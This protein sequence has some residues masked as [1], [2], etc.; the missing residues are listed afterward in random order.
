MLSVYWIAYQRNYK[1]PVAIRG[2]AAWYQLRSLMRRL[3][4]D[5]PTNM[6]VLYYA[7]S[8]AMDEWSTAV[9]CRKVDWGRVS[10][11]GI[12]GPVGKLP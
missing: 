8:L 2:R 12:T 11:S 5:N 3:R 10:A 6:D 1:Q 9:V 7:H 4:R